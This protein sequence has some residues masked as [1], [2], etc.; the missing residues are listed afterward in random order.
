MKEQLPVVI[1]GG[2][3]YYGVYTIYRILYIF[4]VV[5]EGK[6]SCAVVYIIQNIIHL[7]V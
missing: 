7:V 4:I 3:L 2:Q 1:V 6:G 5:E